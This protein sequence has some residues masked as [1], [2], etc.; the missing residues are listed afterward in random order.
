MGSP[1]KVSLNTGTAADLLQYEKIHHVTKQA[2]RLT[3]VSTADQE[4]IV[5][6]WDGELYVIKFD[7]NF[8]KK[9]LFTF[10]KDVEKTKTEASNEA[11][12]PGQA[13]KDA[14]NWEKAELALLQNKIIKNL[15]KRAVADRCHCGHTFTQHLVP[16]PPPAHK[17]KLVA[18]PICAGAPCT[19][20]KTPYGIARKYVGK[21]TEDP[22]AGA[23]TNKNTCII[24]NWVP[25]SEFEQVVV[26]SIQAH[27][28]GP[29]GGVAWTKGDPLRVNVNDQKV[30]RWDFGLARKGVIVVADRTKPANDPD[31]FKNFQGCY[32]KAKKIGTAIGKQ[33]WQIFHMETNAHPPF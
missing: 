31:R 2:E 1:A 18:C 29:L 11:Q 20:F 24:L 4:W 22:L 10:S 3:R 28:K 17:K 32:V 15:D 5:K 9:H 25:K 8:S 12:K 13:G 7:S 21:P 26:Q 30:L 33:T 14:E 16:D 27:E 19:G 6:D 23:T